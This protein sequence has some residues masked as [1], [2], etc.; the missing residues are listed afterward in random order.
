MLLV[1][2]SAYGS[3]LFSKQDLQ[4]Y[5][6]SNRTD[7]LVSLL[8]KDITANERVLVL[9][10]I[11]NEDSEHRILRLKT[12][13]ESINDNEGE[14][15]RLNLVLGRESKWIEN[16][17]ESYAFF[18]RALFLAEKLN[19]QKSIAIASLEIGNN[20]RLGNISNRPFESYFQRA[21][22]LFE[23]L[24]DPLSQS[25]LQYAKVLLEADDKKKVA[26]SEKAIELLEQSISKSDT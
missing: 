8:A 4:E 7:S 22:E 21:I 20:I 3:P 13:L 17:K 15:L 11:K 24:E 6:L 25:Y 18:S 16:I 2:I 19:D 26:Y 10:A 14:E 1:L 23:I 5:Q 9:E 12:Q